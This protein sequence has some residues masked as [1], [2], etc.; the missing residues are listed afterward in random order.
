MNRIHKIT[1]RVVAL[2]VVSLFIHG[3]AFTSDNWAFQEEFI[4]T[5]ALTQVKRVV[6]LD[7]PQPILVWI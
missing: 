2:C 6:L 5:E 4:D 1:S 7:V 3:C